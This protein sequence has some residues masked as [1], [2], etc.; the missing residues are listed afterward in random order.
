VS[1]TSE[2]GGNGGSRANSLDWAA[3]WPARAAGT[4]TGSGPDATGTIATGPVRSIV[5]A[6]AGAAAS[7]GGGLPVRQAAH[8]TAITHPS[9]TRI[10][11]CVTR[12]AAL[13]KSFALACTSAL[14]AGCPS[15]TKLRDETPH[16]GTA[17]AHDDTRIDTGPTMG[18]LPNEAQR[19]LFASREDDAP[20]VLG[21]VAPSMEGRHYFTSNERS[22]HA[23]E[24]TIRGKGGGYVGV[25]TDQAYLFIGWARSEFAW[26]CDYDPMVVDL[27]DVYRALL[28]AA[29]THDEFLELWS[30][31]G[32]LLAHE[33]IDLHAPERDRSHLRALYRKQRSTVARRLAEVVE[34]TSGAKVP[35]WLTDASQYAHVRDL[36]QHGRTRAMLVDLAGRRGL[37]GIGHAAKKAGIAIGVLYLSNAEEYW[38]LYPDAFRRNVDA[39]PYADDAV[40]LRTMLIWKVN[41]DYRYHVQRA[42]NFQAWLDEAWVGNV[43][44][45]TYERPDVD[46]EGMNLFETTS[47]PAAAPS[48]LR[49]A[50][51]KKIEELLAAGITTGGT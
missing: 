44:H 38:R 46:P 35:C 14:F 29:E 4:S 21:G 19:V 28:L 23:F 22:L 3:A 32:R 17:L 16:L 15:H 24:P 7:D 12:R 31:E 51:R 11:P 6:T 1:A 39:L 34:T 20:L 26:L 48:A 42:T 47:L 18:P 45:I 5:D 30:K 50:A 41:R 25:G 49:V 37:K 10:V 27:H 2:S 40:V 36:V 13:V 9:E 8:A 43:Y 33:A